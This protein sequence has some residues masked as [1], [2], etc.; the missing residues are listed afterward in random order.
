[1]LLE[2]YKYIIVGAGLAG[3][4]A[5]EGIREIDKAG[6]ILLVGSEPYLPYNRPPLSKKLWHGK[7]KIEDIFVHDKDYYEK[8]D[9][10]LIVNTKV[11]S[12]ESSLKKII[13]EGGK[14]YTYQRLLLATGGNPRRLTIPGGDLP[15]IFY[16]RNLDDFNTLKKKAKEH[17]SILIIGGGFIGSEMAAALNENKIDVT[18]IYPEKYLV[19]R[20]FPENLGIATTEQFKK[21]GIKILSEDLPTSIEATKTGFI[22]YTRSGLKIESNM[23]LA[24]VGITP[25]IELAESA[26]LKIENGII[27][28]QFLQSSN[29]D[30]FAAGDNANFIYLALD[31][32]MRLEHWDHAK[33]QGKSAGKNMAGSREIYDYMPYFFSDLINIGYEAVGEVDSR[34]EVESIWEK[35]NEK[36]VIYYRKDGRVRGLLMCNVWDKI[37]WARDI[38]IKD[39]KKSFIKSQNNDDIVISKEDAKSHL[40]N[41]PEWSL[42]EKVIVREFNFKDFKQAMEFVEEVAKLAEKVNHHP[43]IFI[44]YNKVRLDFTTHKVDGLTLKDFDLAYEVDRLA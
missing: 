41:L 39:S 3:A 17:S 16:F 36:G 28:D 7:K 13:C 1:M 14:N 19:Q 43:D 26:G 37:P 35:E 6:T 31:K 25:A 42:K 27:V 18:M 24:G 30:I 9:V 20:I 8:N 44:S 10:T 21:H 38:I 32:R 5:V 12:I 11:I 34:L 4:S 29:P 15:G 40:K 22:V 23:I 2:S 33:N